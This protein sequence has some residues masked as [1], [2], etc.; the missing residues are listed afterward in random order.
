MLASVARGTI[1]DSSSDILDLVTALFRQVHLGPIDRRVTNESLSSH[2]PVY[3]RGP[4]GRYFPHC[5]RSG[6]PLALGRFATKLLELMVCLRGSGLDFV[7]V[8]AGVQRKEVV[9][10]TQCPQAK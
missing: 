5:G 4:S 3:C 10:G 8:V 1:P 6:N 7:G 9:P 2:A